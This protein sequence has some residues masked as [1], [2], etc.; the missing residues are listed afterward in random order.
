[1][2][3]W[4]VAAVFA[5][6]AAVCLP[7]PQSSKS[8][9]AAAPSASTKKKTTPRKTTRRRPATVRVS[10]KVRQTALEHVTAYLER[11]ADAPIENPAALVP[12]FEQLHRLQAGEL[13]APL[14]I[15]HYGD[16]HTAAD[17]WTGS[18]RN[19]FQ[20]KFGDGGS[21]YSL[22]GRPWKSYR[23]IDLRGGASSGWRTEGL[24][25]R[26]GDG[27]HGL[28]GVSI[29]ATRPRELIYLE[30]A[31][32]RLELFYLQQPGGGRVQLLD[33][34]E[35]V[36]TLSTDGPL[37][38]GY[39]EYDAS[40]GMHRFDLKTLDRA[41]VRLFGWVTEHPTGVTYEALGING[42]QAALM[43]RWD[44]GLLASHIARRDPALIVLAFGTNEASDPNW[45][46]ESYRE[47]FTTLLR[48]LRQAAPL[49]S[50]LAI[51]PPDRYLRSRG[52]WIPYQRVDRI[53][54]A[55]R[56]ATL[57][58]G[59]AFLDLRAK[60]GGKGAMRDWVLAG[61]AQYDH[62]HFTAGGYRRLGDL[63]FRDLMSQYSTYTE[64]RARI[65]GQT[66]YGAPRENN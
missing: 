38:P 21:G 60:M 31:C 44:E 42:A 13:T 8:S 40:P 10:P 33:N 47:M 48:R 2:R 3:F 41:P 23:R 66:S 53:V 9:K 43:L 4:T 15:L 1:M 25:T 17:E 6:I 29:S 61:L 63:L 19:Y 28:G 14:R 37:G 59:C 64:A 5:A 62:V 34:G 49:A 27:M 51:G 46:Q 45:T 56:E 26:Q 16:S 30:A 22:A 12:F 50:I 58:E 24:I 55:G 52:R 57:A 18:L 39:A 36:D 20:E 7:A 11:A 65:V 54:E 32:A 35:P